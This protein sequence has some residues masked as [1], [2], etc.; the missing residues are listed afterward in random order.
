VLPISSRSPWYAGY[1]PPS[2]TQI[3]QRFETHDAA[4]FL[5]GRGMRTTLYSAASLPQRTAWIGADASV[6]ASNG[7]F[8]LASI[9]DIGRSLAAIVQ[10]L[11]VRETAAP[12]VSVRTALE[13]PA[14]HATALHPTRAVASLLERFNDAIWFDESGL[15]TSDVRQ[16][17]ALAAGEYLINGSGGIGWGLAAS[18]GGA[19]GNPGRQ[20]V[21]AIGD[22]SALYA[23][24]ALWSAAHHQTKNMLLV[25]FANRRYATLN[26]AAE[27]LAGGALQSFTIEPPVLDFSGLATL[28]GWQ[29]ARARS[30]SE[31]GHFLSA[32]KPGAANTLLE[33]VLDPELQPVTAA[34]HF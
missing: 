34:R 6:Q 11:P 3:A 19:I 13:L 22:G 1:L 8:E 9:A 16:W 23:S 33:L 10:R 4:L 32:F 7:E 25:V 5:G 27:R 20:I 15:S 2:L 29:Y 17:M 12:T 26:A 18:V 28:Y 21:A 31:L 30:D 14:A 24:E